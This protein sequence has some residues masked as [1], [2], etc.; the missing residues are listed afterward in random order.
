MADSILEGHG[1]GPDQRVMMV[2][3]REME[4]FEEGRD[5]LRRVYKCNA[6]F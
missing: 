5:E 1:K 2:C 4:A 3:K 6:L